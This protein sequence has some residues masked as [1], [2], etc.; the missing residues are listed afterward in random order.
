[1]I[2]LPVPNPSGLC[3]CGCGGTTPIATRN[4]PARGEWKGQPYR[5]VRGHGSRKQNMWREEDRGYKTPCLIWQGATDGGGYG[6]ATVSG[7]GVKTHCEMYKRHVGPIPSGLELDHLCRQR[8]CG[9]WDHLEA[10]TRAV[11]S[12]RGAMCHLTEDIVHVLRSSQEPITALAVRY[13]VSV[14]S[15]SRAQRGITFR[16]LPGARFS[17]RHPIDLLPPNPD[18]LCQCG[19]GG[20]TPI[21]KYSSRR[22]GVVVGEHVRF[23]HN[24]HGRK[25]PNSVLDSWQE[26]I[27]FCS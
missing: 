26:S 7:K 27:P 8:P 15:V 18:G 3:M 10:V 22:D 12:R 9:Q 5:F 16:E 2:S 6:I 1:M 19:C 21:S 17:K 4:R 23:I 24:H 20:M 25:H 13:N 14:I 11:N